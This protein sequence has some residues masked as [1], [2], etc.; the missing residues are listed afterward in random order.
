MRVLQS[1]GSIFVALLVLISSTSFSVEI[2]RCGGSVADV[3]LFGKAEPCDM[4]KATP[5]CHRNTTIPCCDDD[6]L[7]HDGEDF[8]I[9]KPEV[10]LNPLVQ[11]VVLPPSLILAEIV[12]KPSDQPYWAFPDDPLPDEDRFL[13]YCTLLI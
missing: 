5:S 8:E 11:I 2:H 10:K 12:S 6:E 3:A 4:E 7:L 13:T 9:S 1:I